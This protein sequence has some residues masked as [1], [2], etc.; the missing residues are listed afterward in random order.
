MGDGFGERQTEARVP[1]FSEKIMASSRSRTL[2]N[3]ALTNDTPMDNCI[4]GVNRDEMTVN[5][6]DPFTIEP[7]NDL[8]I[9]TSSEK[10]SAI[11]ILEEKRVVLDPKSGR[12]VFTDQYQETNTTIPVNAVLD[13]RTGQF[14]SASFDDLN[15][16]SGSDYSPSESEDLSSES[17]LSD[18]GPSY[19]LLDESSG[20][21]TKK[22][23]RK[24]QGNALNW[25]R[26]QRKRKRMQGKEYSSIKRSKE[27]TGVME[28]RK[29]RTLKSR[30]CS[31]TCS[32][33]FGKQ[34]N[35][36]SEEDRKEIFKTFWSLSWDE[37]KAYVVAM[38]SHK[39]VALQ[40]TGTISRRTN[41]LTYNL[42]I[43]G[44]TKVVCKK[45]FLNT[46]SLGEWSVSNWV[47]KNPH[48]S[49]IGMVKKNNPVKRQNK[50]NIA[51]VNHVKS[52]LDNLPKM[53]SHYCRQSTNKQY[54]DVQYRTW[55]E[56]YTDFKKYLTE[57]D[58]DNSEKATYKCFLD[59]VHKTNISIYRPKKDQCDVCFAY[60]NKNVPEDEYQLH[61]KSKE[62]ARKEK[63]SD[64]ERCKN[65]DIQMFTV[66][67]QAVQTIPLLSAGSNYFKTKLCV[68]Q[69][70]IY[71]ESDKNVSCYVWHEAEGG[72]DSNIFTSCLIDYLQKLED[73]SRP[74][75][76][77]SDGCCAQNRNTTLS[78]A[79]L[80]YAKVHH[81]E[82]QQK[83]LVVGHTQME[84][85]SVHASIERK[86]K[87]KELYV[88]ADFNTI[89]RK[90]DRIK[91]RKCQ[92]SPDTLDRAIKR[93]N[94]DKISLH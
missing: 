79:L 3:L 67:L 6:S 19:L 63:A 41:T 77:Y 18:S 21:I 23:S 50:K 7:C 84:C 53:P 20:I 10:P 87:G 93:A 65:G 81:A 1:A 33:K 45:M 8:T 74:I 94:D 61:I 25:T 26:N 90:R 28:R 17:S 66:D 68:H 55:A 39:P 73:K 78:N 42:K 91:E 38:V 46:L 62:Q 54:I 47:T 37:K 64:K 80:Y 24:G 9:T 58:I 48:T 88:P 60:K 49:D 72:M 12:F 14:V 22:K 69:F 31:E 13:E 59:A 92:S 29:E 52:F 32:K 15:F 76:I 71:N 35:Q 16:T 5:S 89:P 40:T 2:L 43:S 57:H 34:C 82:I 36:V 56:V 51:K 85:D 86:K 11:K 44:D 70:T 75:V 4:E 27:V 83:Y 30:C